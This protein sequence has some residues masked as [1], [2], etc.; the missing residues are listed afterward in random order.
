MLN[1]NNKINKLIKGNQQI[2]FNGRKIHTNCILRDRI[3][4]TE[5][6]RN[7]VRNFIASVRYEIN[8]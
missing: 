7:T 1:S 2:L 5:L 6:L 8:N 4:S 3:Y